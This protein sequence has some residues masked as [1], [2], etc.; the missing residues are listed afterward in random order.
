MGSL[1]QSLKKLYNLFSNSTN[2]LQSKPFV[3]EGLLS[4]RRWTDDSHCD[5]TSP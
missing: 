2:L 3:E 1:Q 5:Q 4:S